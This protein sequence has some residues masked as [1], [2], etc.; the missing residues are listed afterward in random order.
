[1]FD[2]EEATGVEAFLWNWWNVARRHQ[3]IGCTQR[4]GFGQSCDLIA[5]PTPLI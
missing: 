4:H 3:T 2:V 5:V 1:M